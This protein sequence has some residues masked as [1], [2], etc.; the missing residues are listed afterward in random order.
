MDPTNPEEFPF[1]SAE[2]ILIL[3]PDEAAN[4]ISKDSSA[5]NNGNGSFVS[6]GAA[7]SGT[8]LT[9]VDLHGNLINF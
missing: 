8:G 2:P 4:L 3:N 9:F 5:S 7:K 6:T 1:V